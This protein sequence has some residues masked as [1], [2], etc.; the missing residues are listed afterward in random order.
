MGPLAALGDGFFWLSLRPACGVVASLWALYFADIGQPGPVALWGIA[1]FLVGYNGVHLFLRARL[2]L[3]G[4]RLGDGVVGVIGAARLPH[5]GGRLRLLAA[6]ATGALIGFTGVA[7]PRDLGLPLWTALG[8]WGVF[9]GAWALLHW[10]A[11]AYV[12][13][14]AAAVLALAGG[15]VF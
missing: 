5:F 11:S 6:A 9:A 3:A 7:V 2:F 15:L 13:A 10:G 12:V 8:G 14:Y 4:R 1:V